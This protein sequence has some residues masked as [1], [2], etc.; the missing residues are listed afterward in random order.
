MVVG[1]FQLELFYSIL[2]YSILFYS[3]PFHSIPFHSIPFYSKSM[4]VEAAEPKETRK[5]S[6]D[7]AAYGSCCIL[8]NLCYISHWQCFLFRDFGEHPFTGL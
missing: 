3:I 6:S 2:F 5:Q 4:F 7:I 8:G 1:P